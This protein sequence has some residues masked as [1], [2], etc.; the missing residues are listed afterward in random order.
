MPCGVPVVPA[1]L[2]PAVVEVAA[3][4]TVDVGAGVVFEAA[5]VVGVVL[6]QKKKSEIY[7]AL[8]DKQEGRCLLI[9][10]E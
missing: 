9:F 5:S 10:R 3:E 7:Q 6:N 8:E 1:V 4:L 2:E